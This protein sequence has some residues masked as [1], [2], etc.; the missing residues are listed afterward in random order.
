MKIVAP[1]AI[2]F[3][4]A[5]TTCVGASQKP[6]PPPSIAGKYSQFNTIC[7]VGN[8]REG[9]FDWVNCKK[10]ESVLTVK[11]SDD[12]Y[13]PFSVEAELYF[14]NFHQCSFSGTARWAQDRLIATADNIEEC[15]VSVFFFDGAA[16]LAASPE[17]RDLC[18]ARGSLDGQIL[19]R[20]K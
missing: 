15:K 2:L 9:N 7:E 11:K 13:L 18:G 5:S 19:K 6:S 20:K 17:C 4:A 10:V 1:L 12:K 14:A 3:L 16:H 8:V